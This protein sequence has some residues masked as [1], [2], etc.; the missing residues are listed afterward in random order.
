[1]KFAFVIHN[2]YYSSR[3]SELLKE[4]G[5]DYYTRWDE[6][7][8]KGHGTE[9]HLGEGS[10]QSTNAVLMIAFEEEAPLEDLIEKITAANAQIKRADDKIRLFQLPLERIV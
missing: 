5:I 2:S 10:F 6:V 3:V 4:T 1:M 8:G 7:K 9:P